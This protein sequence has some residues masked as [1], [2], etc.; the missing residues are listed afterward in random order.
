MH[1]LC[2]GD[3]MD[4]VVQKATELG[5]SEILPVITE[6]GIVRLDSARSRKRTDHWRGIA[7]S[8]CEQSG[9]VR[10]PTVHPPLP[11]HE[12]LRN[13]PEQTSQ[14]ARL[15]FDPTGTED[16]AKC[17]ANAQ[18]ITVLTGPEGGFS[19]AEKDAAERAGFSQLRLGP[20][21]LRTETAAL[22]ALSVVQS[23]AGDL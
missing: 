15:M 17:I 11:L 22:V 5:I 6:H 23:M 7:I 3:R 2:K 1:G 19:P 16:L 21:I 14:H 12:A 9:R 10:I 18:E 4:Y 8:A 13:L 20:R